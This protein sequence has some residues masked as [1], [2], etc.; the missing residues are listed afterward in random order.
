VALTLATLA[1]ALLA[2]GTA[3]GWFFWVR[4]TT[5]DAAKAEAEKAVPAEVRAYL[6]EKLP[7]MVNEII[8]PQIEGLMALARGAGQTPADQAKALDEESK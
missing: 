8:T 2:L 3:I 1:L 7:A 4:M 6:D 5:K